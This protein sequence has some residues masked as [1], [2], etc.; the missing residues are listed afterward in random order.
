MDPVIAAGC[1]PLLTRRSL[2]F[3]S[4]AAE[5]EDDVVRRMGCATM[6]VNAFVSVSIVESK[7]LAAT[8]R[9]GGIMLA[10]V[11]SSPPPAAKPAA[12]AK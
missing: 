10:S 11:V 3:S 12:L 5:D 4:R 2:P 7:R 9:G 1:L 8:L 6:P